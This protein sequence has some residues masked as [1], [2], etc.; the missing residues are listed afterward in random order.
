MHTPA[1]A[2]IS[3]TYCI[4]SPVPFAPKV[5]WSHPWP[6]SMIRIF[7]EIWAQLF[8]TEDSFLPQM[9]SFISVVFNLAKPEILLLENY[10]F[11]LSS[12]FLPLLYKGFW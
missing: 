11:S 8:T 7:A 4:T 6:D 2:F 9:L 10:C 12:I 3:Q 5:T 1:L